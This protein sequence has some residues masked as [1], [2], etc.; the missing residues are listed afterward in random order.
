MK[1]CFISRTS[2]IGFKI[3]NDLKDNFGHDVTEVKIS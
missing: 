1:I 2:E 3:A